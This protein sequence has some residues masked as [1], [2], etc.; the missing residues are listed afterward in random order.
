[1]ITI[2]ENTLA[3][4]C[5][6]FGV[7]PQSLNYK[8][9]S[10]GAVYLCRRGSR[11]HMLKF[12]PKPPEQLG[13]Y[14]EKLA[15]I[16]YLA[17]NG[18][19]LA[20]P[21]EAQSGRRYEVLPGAQGQYVVTLTLLADGRHPTPRNPVDWTERLFSCWGQVM[22]KMHALA[23][24]YPRWQKAAP[25]EEGPPSLVGDWREEHEFFCGWSKEARITEQFRQLYAPLAALPVERDS[26]GLIHNDLHMW[27][28]LYNLN[29]R[30]V[31]P[32][33][34]IDFDVCAYHWFLTDIAIAAYHAI[35]TG[36]HK[37]LGKR[38]AFARHFLQHFMGGYR[39]ENDLA[40]AWLERLPLF[41]RYRE[42]LSYIALSNEWP[43]GKRAGWQAAM[44][45]EKRA[46]I[47]SGEALVGRL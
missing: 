26:F 17:E 40:P 1:M 37:N 45:N 34:I 14:E 46:R 25:G 5:A 33:T 16:I 35:T 44:L 7:D 12:V 39:Q 11:A 8:G 13:E 23:R 42:I 41:L 20:A 28:F 10:D 3:A 9:G 6:L 30:G 15:F 43:E 31:F 38:E 4:G 24:A 2:D 27:N 36:S 22:G 19:P 47:L 18:V 21:L 32:I 29:A